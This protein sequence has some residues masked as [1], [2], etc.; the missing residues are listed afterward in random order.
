[1]YA[2][3]YNDGDKIAEQLLSVLYW[4]HIKI[5]FGIKINN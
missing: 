1:L 2:Q 4:A 5:T 3:K